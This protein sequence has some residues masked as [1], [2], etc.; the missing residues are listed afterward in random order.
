MGKLNRKLSVAAVAMA[1]VST[2][3]LAEDKQQN[4]APSWKA[5]F[6]KAQPQEDLSKSVTQVF[7]D[8][9]SDSDEDTK[10]AKVAQQNKAKAMAAEKSTSESVTGFWGRVTSFFAPLTKWWNSLVFVR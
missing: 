10:V 6:E 1:L 8:D 3:T 4:V 7:Y 5:R 9:E 2:A